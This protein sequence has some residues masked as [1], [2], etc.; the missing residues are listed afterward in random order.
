MT[1]R[2][3]LLTKL[4]VLLSSTS[5]VTTAAGSVHAIAIPSDFVEVKETCLVKTTLS[6]KLVSNSKEVFP[7]VLINF[8]AS[9][10]LAKPHP[11]S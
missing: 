8:A 1:L 4:L 7:L 6:V 3:K 11:Y 10:P 2:S 5:A 9:L